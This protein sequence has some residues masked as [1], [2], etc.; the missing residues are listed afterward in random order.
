MA[1]AFARHVDMVRL[2]GGVELPNLRQA[3]HFGKAEKIALCALT[4]GSRLEE[5]ANA[6]AMTGD[7]ERALTEARQSRGQ[8]TLLSSKA[9]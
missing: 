2:A 8:I 9:A 5:H 1:R 6:L 4:L 7:V 3:R